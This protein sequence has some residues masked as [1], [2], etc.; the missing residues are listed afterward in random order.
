MLDVHDLEISGPD[1]KTIEFPLS[2][3]STFVFRIFIRRTWRAKGEYNPLGEP[4]YG[5]E[6]QIDKRVKDIPAE[7]CIAPEKAKAKKLKGGPE[8]A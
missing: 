7:F 8:V 1:S 6:V 5:A 3:G 4:V 2:D